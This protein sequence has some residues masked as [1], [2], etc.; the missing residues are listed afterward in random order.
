MGALTCSLLGT[1]LVFAGLMLLLMY[2]GSAPTAHVEQQGAFYALVLLGMAAF[3]T[4]E[5]M[6]V[7]RQP[8][9]AVEKPQAKEETK[10]SWRTH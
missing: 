9:R 3:G 2:K 8:K 5:Q 10:G 4:L 6:L 7:C 1:A